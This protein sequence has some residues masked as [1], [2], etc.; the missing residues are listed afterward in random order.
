MDF[1]Y[2]SEILYKITAESQQYQVFCDI[3]P[4]SVFNS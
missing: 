1:C 4:K 3:D 2:I